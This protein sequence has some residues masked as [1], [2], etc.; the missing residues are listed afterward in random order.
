MGDAAVAKDVLYR[1]LLKVFIQPFMRSRDYVGPEV[2]E[3]A[4]RAVFIAAGLSDDALHD[5]SF[6]MVDSGYEVLRGDMDAESAWCDCNHAFAQLRIPDAKEGVPM[7]A[8]YAAIRRLWNFRYADE[9]GFERYIGGL[10]ESTKPSTKGWEQIG[11][12]FGDPWEYGGTWYS[13]QSD[14]IIH[15]PGVE[16]EG[17]IESKSPK[18]DRVMGAADYRKIVDAVNLDDFD[19]WENI[20]DEIRTNKAEQ[21]TA[22]VRHTYY[23]CYVDDSDTIDKDW[24]REIA[25]VKSECEMSDEDWAKLPASSKEEAIANRIGWEEFDHQPERITRAA[26]AVLLGIEDL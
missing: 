18:V 22:A 1:K 7:S 26:L 4:W 2:D 5:R 15:F 9:E 12:D 8:E 16:S 3:D 10:T 24:A 13:K 20:E 19:A 6:R 11:G 14:N 17:E 21:L 25:E 23:R